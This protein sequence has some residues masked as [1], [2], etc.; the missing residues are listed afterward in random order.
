MRVGSRF[1]GS[2]DVARDVL[3]EGAKG[4]PVLLVVVRAVVEDAR[5]DRSAAG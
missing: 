5:F 1:I 3:W 4:G 2:C